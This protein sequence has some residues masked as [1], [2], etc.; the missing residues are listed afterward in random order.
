VNAQGGE[1][2]SGKRMS[3]TASVRKAKDEDLQPTRNCGRGFD[4]FPSWEETHVTEFLAPPTH[5]RY[6]VGLSPPLYRASHAVFLV[7][8]S[9]FAM[10]ALGML[11]LV[12]I[13]EVAH[14]VAPA[15]NPGMN[16]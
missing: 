2:F 12:V 15:N 7:I 14:L 4:G 6:V 5:S 3:P 9:L 1:A 13:T 16:R 11:I 8:A 10:A